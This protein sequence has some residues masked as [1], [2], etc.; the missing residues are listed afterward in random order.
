[1]RA[2]SAEPAARRSARRGENGSGL[3]GTMFGAVVF[4]AFVALA[5]NTLVGLYA[6]SV[7]TS[8]AW[9]AAQRV[10]VSPS[11]TSVDAA[12]SR[13]RQRLSSFDNVDFVWHQ[14]GDAVG[15]SVTADR[16]SLL[17][18]ALVRSTGATR[19]ERTVWVRE[20]IAR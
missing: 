11:A 15:L 18:P 19:I 1:M 2:S 10:A 5:A 6:T 16:P 13:A 12:E 14:D 20:E 3:I 7:T 8:V 17:P 4:L 9:D